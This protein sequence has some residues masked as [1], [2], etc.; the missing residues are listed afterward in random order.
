M[1]PLHSLI[2]PFW[3]VVCSINHQWIFF[4]MSSGPAKCSLKAV[5][6]NFVY[7]LIW[8]KRSS[9]NWSNIVSGHI[10]EGVWEEITQSAG[11]SAKDHTSAGGHQPM[12]EGSCRTKTKRRACSLLLLMLRQLS[13]PVWRH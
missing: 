11:S 1:L 13:S 3:E 12:F 5:M 7:Q 10:F 4:L 6:V 9:C 2:L 8:A